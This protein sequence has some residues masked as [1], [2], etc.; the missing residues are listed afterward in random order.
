LTTLTVSGEGTYTANANGT[1]TF[2]PLP[3]FVG[4]AAAV[5]YAVTDS[6]GQLAG[7]T[8]T[9]TVSNPAVPV[10][11]PDAKAVI[12]GG[13]VT[14]AT[15]TGANGLATAT[16]GLN[17]SMTCLI[18]PGSSP[19]A[20]DADGIVTVAGVGTYTLN[21][22]TGVVTLVADPSA[23]Q[24][25]KASLKYQVTDMFGQKA[26]STLTPTIPPAPSATSDTSTG[27]FDTNQTISVLTNDTVVSPVTFVVTSVKLCATTATANSA[28]TLTTLTVSGEGTYTANANGTIT[29]DPL[30][31]FVGTAAAVKYAVTDS[32]GQ[33]AGATVTPTV[34]NP[35]APTATA[36]APASGVFDTNQTVSLLAN[37]M[38]GTSSL[39]LLASTLRLC[40]LAAVT[41]F[42]TTNCNLVPTQ[43]APLITADGSY[44]ID[45]VTGVLTFD[46]ASTFVGTVTQPIRYVVLDGLNQVATATVTLQVSSPAAPTA[47]PQTKVVAPGTSITY[48]NLIGANALASGAGLQTGTTNGP[49]LINPAG[50]VCGATV[51]IAGEGTWTVDRTTGIVTFTALSTITVG[52]KTPVTYKV[53]DLLGQ[54]ATSTLTPIVPTAPVAMNDLA[55]G[56][57]G[58]TQTITPLTND[59]FAANAPVVLSSVKL[60]A[61]GETPNNCTRTTL[62]VANEGTYSVN[63]SGVISFVPLATFTGSATSVVYQVSNIAGNVVHANITVTVTATGA[64]PVASSTPTPSPKADEVSGKKG[65]KIFFSPWLNDSPGVLAN[66]EMVKIDPTSLRL[67]GAGEKAPKCSRT[68]L[69]T[70]DGKYFVDTKTGKVTFVPRADF[71]GVTKSVTYQIANSWKGMQKPGIASGTLTATV[72]DLE[73]PA[74]GNSSLTMALYAGLILMLGVLVLNRSSFTCRP[75]SDC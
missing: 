40:P 64:T 1:I 23:T 31:T 21:T 45:P 11:T 63:S 27:A 74:T 19:D 12:A 72:T 50:N 34:S 29:F 3:T 60:C 51:T 73:L 35:A 46:P 53:T 54:T 44:W 32:T 18:T 75:A 58:A 7:A 39:P 61:A 25:T 41:P 20:C 2:D 55:T 22:T 13:T 33:L 4:T 47:T 37:D 49:C 8:V 43:S 57:R 71:V 56:N 66:N 30:P 69:V 17:A 70:A 52:T 62:T 10:A 59:T 65:S 9:P 24:G 36:D 15:I 16:G 6:T 28:C 14:F 48:T 68:S 67:C 26:T 42:T 38:P 5:K